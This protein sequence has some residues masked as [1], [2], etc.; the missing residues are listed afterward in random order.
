MRLSRLSGTVNFQ[1]A[2]GDPSCPDLCGSGAIIF[3]ASLFHCLCI[4]K[5]VRGTVVRAAAEEV[6]YGRDEPVPE[7]FLVIMPIDL[8][9][10]SLTEFRR[11]RCD[12]LGLRS[13]PDRTRGQHKNEEHHWKP[14]PRNHLTLRWI[15]PTCQSRPGR[16]NLRFRTLPTGLSFSIDLYPF[17][18]L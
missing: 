16:A 1:P 12:L 15:K 2:L 13:G 6:H 11:H 7:A 18:T 10:R 17:A 9:N 3:R 5:L 4:V 14:N 8:R